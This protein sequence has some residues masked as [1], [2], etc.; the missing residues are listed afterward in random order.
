MG[1]L[2]LTVHCLR[3]QT[4]AR[5]AINEGVD[6]ATLSAELKVWI[7]TPQTH[8]PDS[9]ARSQWPRCHRG[10]LEEV[11]RRCRIP[12]HRSNSW[13]MTLVALCSRSI[14]SSM[15]HC[16]IAGLRRVSLDR[17]GCQCAE[18]RLGGPRHR[19]HQRGEGTPAGN[20]ARGPSGGLPMEALHVGRV[21]LIQKTRPGVCRRRSHCRR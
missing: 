18:A 2:V 20:N 17:Q 11:R 8:S 1:V 5:D 4:N 10:D 9:L 16:S 21:K 12:S 14:L 6:A 13:S 19:G 15:P 7:V 3:C